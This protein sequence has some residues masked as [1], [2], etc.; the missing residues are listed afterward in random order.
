MPTLGQQFVHQ[1]FIAKRK[2]DSFMND[3]VKRLSYMN[4]SFRKIAIRSY[5][6]LIDRFVMDDSMILTSMENYELL[7][8]YMAEFDLILNRYRVEYR[9]TYESNRAELFTIVKDKELRLMKVL[10]RIGIEDDRI[11]ISQNNLTIVNE[12]NRKMYKN[13]EAILIK[14]RNYVYDTFFQGITQSQTKETLRANFL[15]ENGTLK[16]GSSLEG[17]TELEAAMGIVA[18]RTAFLREKAKENGYAMCWNVNPMDHRTKPICMEASLAGVIREA[19]MGNVYGFPP[20]Y[21]CRCE[22]AY[23]HEDW[24]EFN[25]A[26]NNELKSVRLRLI[27]ELRDAPRQL[28]QYYIAGKLVL[29]TDPVRR[30]G[31]KM[32]ADIEEKLQ[33]ALE[34]EVPD[35]ME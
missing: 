13:V 15:N 3:L 27:D 7:S 12:I 29:P 4:K 16:I 23:T 1:A 31:L 14:W 25:Q 9:K 26:I 34:N 28:A 11:T 33:T 24:G 10:K 22:I 21:V 30:A 35:I 18:E 5:D 32:Y 8:A 2:S 17:M 20:R 19:E 6:R